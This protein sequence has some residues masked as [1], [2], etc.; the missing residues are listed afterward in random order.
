MLALVLLA[1]PVPPAPP[2][3]PPPRP[4]VHLLPTG[5]V[6]TDEVVRLEDL[7]AGAA[8]DRV[9]VL[10][11]YRE[12]VFVTFTPAHAAPGVPGSPA[13]LSIP[14]SGGRGGH[15]LPDLGRG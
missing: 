8:D 9:K 5:V 7:A 4:L 11:R 1:S 15:R 10:T 3:A 14:H 6:V 2:V 12:P 13:H